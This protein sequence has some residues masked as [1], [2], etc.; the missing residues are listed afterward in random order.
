LTNKAYI[1]DFRDANISCIFS[2]PQLN[3][4]LLETVIEGT[5]AHTA[6]FDPL[7]SGLEPGR[8]LYSQLLLDLARELA[9]CLRPV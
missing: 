8:T 2:E 6:T 7:G 4:S 1:D 3:G 5:D 9:D